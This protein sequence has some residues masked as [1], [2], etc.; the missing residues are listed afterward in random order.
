MFEVTV[1]DEM[2]QQIMGNYVMAGVVEPDMVACTIEKLNSYSLP[3]LN[4][5][6]ISS[7]ETLKL[8]CAKTAQAWRN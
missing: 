3:L 6:L 4:T 5:C 1:Q 2:I 7:K 8:K